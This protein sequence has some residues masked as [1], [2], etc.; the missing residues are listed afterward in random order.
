MT[1]KTKD[2]I[3]EM[4]KTFG[5][6][7]DYDFTHSGKT[8]RLVE[9]NDPYTKLKPGDTGIIEMIHKHHDFNQIWIKWRSGSGLMLIDPPD[10]YVILE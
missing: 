1:Q 2:R 5:K 7:P 10:K 4:K 8:I 3:N 6:Y 9:T